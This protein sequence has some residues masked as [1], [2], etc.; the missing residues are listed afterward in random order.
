MNTKETTS[1]EHEDQASDAPDGASTLR[2]R[3]HRLL[4]GRSVDRLPFVEF[5]NLFWVHSLRWVDQGMPR[6]V[7]PFVH[8]GFDEADN[9]RAT[10]WLNCGRGLEVLQPDLYALPRFE[11]RPEWTEG[12][13]FHTFDVRNG[14]TFKRLRA[15][16]RGD[17]SVKTH[18]EP[19]V[20]TREDWEK[21]RKRFD[22]H[23]PERYPRLRQYTHHLPI[24]PPDYPDTWEQV[25]ADT[26]SASHLVTLGMGGGDACL[27]N[28]MGLETFL[29]SL[30][31]EPEWM[32]EM[33]EYV[34]WFIR[35]AL[36][37]AVET[38]RLDFV[39]LIGK[40]SPPRTAHGELL[41]GP[42]MFLKFFGRS[43]EQALDLAAKNSVPYIRMAL[44][45]NIPFDDWVFDQ[46]T[47]RGL[48]PLVEADAAGKFDV[49][50][51]RNRFGSSTPLIG[52]MDVEML[53][54][55]PA[56][57]DGMLDK[58]FA[59]A[60]EGRFVPLLN[61]RYAK[62]LEVPLSQYAY[63]TQ[64]FRVRNGMPPR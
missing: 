16:A 41:I 22:P 14:T 4:D 36:K 38:A 60:S 42:E 26:R 17:L 10:N 29:E 24:Y 37:K 48:T 63:Y 59:R 39:T 32:T 25:V 19:P 40:G 18:G 11:P 61:D 44:T 2:S 8:F 51:L 5:D 57:M 54:E 12:E 3:W 33:A 45:R 1:D 52:G 30:L 20:K 27:S 62:F 13:Y 53:L 21:Y 55:G 7:N 56:A 34:G 46:I 28:A 35:E 43:Y 6:D 23:A 64:G 49:E 9:D 50:A 15:R 58:A 31:S 47:R